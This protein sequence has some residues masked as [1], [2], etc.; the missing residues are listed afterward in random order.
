MSQANPVI[1]AGLIQSWCRQD[2]DKDILTFVQIDRSGAF[3]E[4][5][6]SYRQLWDNG[7]RLAAWM[8]SQ[9]MERVTSSASSCR[10]TPSSST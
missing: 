8:R 5:T 9:G 4:T 3:E 2:P 1:L 6:R 10:T 7:Q